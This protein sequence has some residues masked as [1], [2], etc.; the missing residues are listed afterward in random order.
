MASENKNLGV[1]VITG[2]ARGIGRALA[3]ILAMKGIP[4]YA[5]D[6]YAEG[7]DSLKE[8]YPSLVTIKELD[9]MTVDESVAS[10]LANEIAVT[11]GIRFLVHNAAHTPATPFGN[12]EKQKL[13]DIFSVNVFAP[14]LLTQAFAPHL[15]AAKGRVMHNGSVLA[16]KGF[17]GLTG[18][19]LSKCTLNR[20]ADQNRL[21]FEGLEVLFTN[22]VPGPTNTKSFWDCHAEAEQLELPLFKFIDKLIKDGFKP[23]EP[24]ETA[25]FLH[26]ILCA[27]TNEEYESREWNIRDTTIMEKWKSYCLLSQ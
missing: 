5:I 4:I 17:F 11:P 26:W 22:I 24:E 18:Y 15:K 12:I 21:E 27:T 7:L 20:L 14:I 1:A 2:A 9:I 13:Q 16:H 19:L 25:G 23:R 3:R 8:E 6:K 10:E